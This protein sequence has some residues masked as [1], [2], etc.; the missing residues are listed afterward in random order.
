MPPEEVT[1][2]VLEKV[3]IIWQQIELRKREQKAEKGCLQDMKFLVGIL[4]HRVAG[5][6]ILTEG[7]RRRMTD[8][9]LEIGMPYEPPNGVAVGVET[10]VPP[11]E[12]KTV[13]VQACAPQV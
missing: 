3:E 1:E 11:V 12:N 5:L 6:T 4:A 8:A 2:V 13:G 10:H 9:G 7:W